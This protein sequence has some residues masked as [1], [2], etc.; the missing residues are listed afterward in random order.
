MTA[1]LFLM[2]L[3]MLFGMGVYYFFFPS[4][5]LFEASMTGEKVAV[6]R[7]EGM[8]VDSEETNRQ[9]KKW[10][11]DKSVKAIVLRIDSPGGAVAPSQEIYNALLRAK[12]KK[13]V[14]ASMGSVAA[15]GGYY[16]AVACDKI[17][18]DPGTLTGSIGVIMMFDNFEKLWDKIGLKSVV[19]KS[20]KF[21]DTGSPFRE[22][23]DE[24]KALIQGIIDDIY[25]QFITD[26][27]A[28]R[29][30][31]LEEVRKLADGRIYTGKQALDRKLVDE[32]GG[33]QVAI[34][35]A[36]ELAKIDGEPKIVEEEEE[37]SFLRW[38]LGDEL[39]SKI[40]ESVKPK[41]GAYYLW[42]AW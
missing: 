7:V 12:E 21:K 41:S 8:I 2:L 28:G 4:E 34:N 6:V 16:I 14:I 25:T 30:M 23:T 35:T 38:M 24:D 40:A 19:F 37:E 18:A 27:A 32:M 10:A 29:Q 33:M 42:P 3:L 22:V 1:L 36:G 9:I 5:D 15:S 31:D 11:K 26:V 20:G 39:N 13:P 17:I